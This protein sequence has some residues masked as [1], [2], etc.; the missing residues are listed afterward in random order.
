MVN[1]EPAV[2]PISRRGLLSAA[3]STGIAAALAGGGLAGAAD[4]WAGDQ[5]GSYPTSQAAALKLLME[6]NE[7]WARGRPRHP[8]QS[9]AWRH[10]V[11]GHQEPFATVVSCIDSRVPPEIVFDRGLGDLFVIRTGAQTLDDL[12]VLGSVEFGPDGYPSARLIFVLGHARCGAV[13]AAISAI[14]SGKRAPGHIQAVV[15]A[16]RPAYHVAVRQP[17][18]LVDNMIRAQTKLTV[19]RLKRD[20]LLRRL[21]VSDGLRI[22][23]GHYDLD[24]GVVK[25]IA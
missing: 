2:A 19:Q 6:G 12:V 1:V 10:H 13:T 14:E 24:T 17:G 16:L 8:H 7:R 15:D 3:G 4:A 21:I 23:G 22:V 5:P 9:V 25:I 20:P 18:D 11:A